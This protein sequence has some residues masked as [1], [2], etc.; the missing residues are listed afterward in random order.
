MVDDGLTAKEHKIGFIFVFGAMQ[1]FTIIDDYCVKKITAVCSFAKLSVDVEECDEATLKDLCI[2]AHGMVLQTVSGGAISQQNAIL[3]YLGNIAALDLGMS[4]VSSLEIAQVDQWLSTVWADVE[5]PLQMLMA[6]SSSTP[7]YQVTPEEKLAMDSQIKADISKSL[8]MLEKHLSGKNFFV[9]AR[10]TIVDVAFYCVFNEIVKHNVVKPSAALSAWG[11]AICKHLAGDASAFP[12]PAVASLATSSFTQGNNG[13]AIVCTQGTT[14]GCWNRRRIRVKELLAKGQ[15]IAGENI[16]LKG[17]IRTCRSAEK[18]KVFFIELTD[19]STV[20]SVQLVLNQDSSEGMEAAVNCGGVGG[21]VSVNGVVAISPSKGQAIEIQVVKIEV[22]GQVFGG[23]DGTVGG[24]NYPMA[25]KAHSL[26]FLREKAHLRIRSKVFSSAMRMRHAMAFATHKFFNDLG[27][28]Y[29]HTPLIT[30]ADCEGAGEQFCVTSLLPEK[31]KMAEVPTTKEGNV[32]FSK[33]FFGRR[34][35]MTVSGQLNVETHAA[36]LSD[37]Y[38]FGPSFRAENSHTSRHLAE[39]WMIE[40]EI[41]FA[42]LEDNM[43]LAVSL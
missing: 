1:L 19:G 22:L 27:F 42:S 25:K 4:G 3:R 36:G 7:Q 30:A 41:C 24:K 37:V 20:K 34:C 43:A 21:S 13:S 28:V 18:G 2:H 5:V 31:A 12:A 8:D 15:T 33:D 38:T 17:W 40:P 35:C 9:G 14:Q 26:E 10:L 29:T 39:F 6:L 11:V 16:I 23:V 32:D